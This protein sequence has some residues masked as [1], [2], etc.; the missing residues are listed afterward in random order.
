MK[1]KQRLDSKKADS[2]L[3]IFVAVHEAYRV[4]YTVK[5]DMAGIDVDC[6]GQLEITKG[7][8][9]LKTEG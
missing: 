2:P 3:S 8:S 9:D 4:E 6:I 5:V 1:I 7:F